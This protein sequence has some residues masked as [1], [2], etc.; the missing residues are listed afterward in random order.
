[1]PNTRRRKWVA[2]VDI[3]MRL[4]FLLAAVVSLTL[5]IVTGQR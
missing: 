2:K 3:A 5:S 4:G 1:M